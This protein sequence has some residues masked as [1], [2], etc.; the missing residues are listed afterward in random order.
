M[1]NARRTEIRFLFAATSDEIWAG[2]VFNDFSFGLNLLRE[3]V[4]RHRSG[5]GLVPGKY[6][7]LTGPQAGI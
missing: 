1:A 5:G 2:L 4:K 7:L 3:V 6:N